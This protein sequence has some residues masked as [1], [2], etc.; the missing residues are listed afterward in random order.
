MNQK[1][2]N[3]ATQHPDYP[4]YLAYRKRSAEDPD[5]EDERYVWEQDGKR[6]YTVV[7]NSFEEW[8]FRK[9]LFEGI[10]YAESL[11]QKDKNRHR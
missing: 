3:D 2:Y 8:Q 7:G 6:Y 9:A 10:A 4:S 11:R 1:R 5:Y